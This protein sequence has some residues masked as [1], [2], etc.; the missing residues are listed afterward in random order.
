[1]VY[2]NRGNLLLFNFTTKYLYNFTE[3]EYQNT[4]CTTACGLGDKAKTLL[5]K[6]EKDASGFQQFTTP[7]ATKAVERN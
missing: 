6:T 4:S 7:Q 3:I 2:V 5:A 1:M